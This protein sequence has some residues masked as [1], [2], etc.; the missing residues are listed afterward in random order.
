LR[1]RRVALAQHL[2]QHDPEDRPLPL[3]RAPQPLELLGV[4][5]AARL[6]AQR[7]ALARKRLLQPDAGG[8]RRLDHLVTRDLQQPAVGG[9]GDGPSRYRG[10][11]ANAGA[12]GRLHRTAPHRAVDA[13]LEQP[14]DTRFANG[15]AEAADLRRVARQS[16]LEMFHAGE[17]LPVAVLRPAFYQ[18]L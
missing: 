4:G 10:V 12:P 16:W 17:E 8:L 5:V 11:A 2:P 7:L 9:I 18:R 6:A 1:R 13:R 3:E 14:L 15:A